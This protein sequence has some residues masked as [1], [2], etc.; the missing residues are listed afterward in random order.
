MIPETG[1]Q[2]EFKR[3]VL[4]GVVVDTYQCGHKHVASSDSFFER[5]WPDRDCNECAERKHRAHWEQIRR[6]N[7]LLAYRQ[8]AEYEAEQQREQA[9]IQGL[10]RFLLR[11]FGRKEKT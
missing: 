7:A 2:R 6:V 8:L 1:S 4:T 10:G 5:D 3:W 11:W 9:K